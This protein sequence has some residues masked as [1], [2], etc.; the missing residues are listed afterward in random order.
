M[1]S[2]KNK[3]FNHSLSIRQVGWED[4]TCV[5]V[6]GQELERQTAC[7]EEKGEAELQEGLH[8]RLAR[9]FRAFSSFAILKP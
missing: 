6:T 3:E 8:F 4:A 5:D 9:D 1:V 7:G 2:L